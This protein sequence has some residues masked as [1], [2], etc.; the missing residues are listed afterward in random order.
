MNFLDNISDGCGRHLLKAI[1]KVDHLAV[2]HYRQ[3]L[4]P[5]DIRIDKRRNIV[6][7]KEAISYI[8]FT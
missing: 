6:N 8:Q 7:K 3:S 2:T 1:L 5:N 4:N